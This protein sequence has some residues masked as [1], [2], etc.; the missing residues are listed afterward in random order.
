MKLVDL[1]KYNNIV[2]QVHDSPD[3]DAVGSGYAIYKYFESKG[4]TV[5]LVYG[6][7][8]DINKSNMRLLIEELAIPIEHVTELENPE[9]LITVDCQYGQGNVQYFP[10]QNIAMIDHHNTGKSSD[11]MAEIRSNLVSCA[12]VCYA[13]F[14]EAKYEVNNDISVATALYYGLY[15]DS[16]QLSEI[17]HPL[18]RD[19]V[20]FL[21]YDRNLINKLRYANFSLGD[22]EIAG[23]AIIRHSYIDKHRLAIVNSKPCDPNIL[24]FIGD[25]M[26]QVDNVDVCIVFNEC[27]GGYKLSI[28][29]CVLDVAANELAG[30][31]T[32]GIGNGGGH[33]DKAG[34]FIDHNRFDELYNGNSIE[35]YLMMRMDEYYTS[36]EVIHYNKTKI[37]MNTMKLYRKTQGIQGFVKLTD[38][39][40][41]GSQCKLR[42]LEGDVMIVVRDDLYVMIG[43]FGEV[44]PIEAH[45]FYEKYTPIEGKYQDGFDYSPSIIDVKEGRPYDLVECAKLCMSRQGG[46]IYARPLSK[47]TKLFTKWNYTTYMSGN[48]GDMLCCSVTD[49]CDMHIVR[50][51]VFESTYEEV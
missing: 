29:S 16:N 28:R 44:Y 26:V 5:R 12:T 14:K 33:I 9:L 10:A 51:E 23:I 15:M 27:A 21:R 41:K 40:E 19:M 11:D 2:I 17:T 4:K 46:T 37:D 20:D 50:K 31:I 3:A 36:F 38:V 35:A 18:D 48:A 1:D 24:G 25:L 49:R 43:R 47:N 30:Y 45:D 34:G 32:E 7:K 13:L 39:F 8:F 22:L 6:G 42:T